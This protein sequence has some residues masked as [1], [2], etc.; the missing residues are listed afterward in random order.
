LPRGLPDV[1]PVRLLVDNDVLLKAAHW[2]LLD[3]VPEACNTTWEQVAVLP[4]LIHRTRKV[5]PK[6]FRDAAVAGRLL[7]RLVRTT[8]LPDPDLAVI[9]ALNGI[10]GLDV[11]EVQ[12]LAV[13]S[14]H[15]QTALLTGDKRA[16]RVCAVPPARPALARCVG[17]VLCMDSWLIHVLHRIGAETLCERVRSRIDLDHAML[18]VLGREGPRSAAHVAEGLSSYAA[19][20]GREVD[21]LLGE[22][23]LQL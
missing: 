6:L 1:A 18:A 12:L 15:A 16:L 5:D 3:F 9:D 23:P 13:L 19:A 2:D 21:G 4:Q 14:G 20:I 11:G 8:T 10:V 22:V 17:R 7:D